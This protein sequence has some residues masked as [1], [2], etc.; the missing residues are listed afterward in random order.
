MGDIQQKINKIN[1]NVTSNL[2]EIIFE[3]HKQETI[4]IQL[5]YRQ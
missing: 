3:E 4:Y 2:K 1:N 5:F